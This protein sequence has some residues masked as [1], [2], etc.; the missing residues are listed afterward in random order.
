MLAVFVRFPYLAL[1]DSM[2]CV[3]LPEI[4]TLK[5]LSGLR[6]PQG[7]FQKPVVL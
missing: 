1:D 4:I 5:R 2:F 7:K 6:F 3:V